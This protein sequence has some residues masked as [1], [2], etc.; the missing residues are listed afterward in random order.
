MVNTYL[1]TYQNKPL[2]LYS[3]MS[4]LFDFIL[5]IFNLP[6]NNLSLIKFTIYEYEVNRGYPIN[7]FKFTGDSGKLIFIEESKKRV[8]MNKETFSRFIK[9]KNKYSH[10]FAVKKEEP[11]IE[12]PIKQIVTNDDDIKILVENKNKV[13]N[14]LHDTISEINKMKYRNKQFSNWYNKFT[15]DVALFNKFTEELKKDEKFTIPKLFEQKFCFFTELGCDS[16][17]DYF[18]K[19]NTNSELDL[20]E[21]ENFLNENEDK[22]EDNLN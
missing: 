10:I 20:E 11:K 19:F 21:L 3:K 16:F 5:E 14:K 2:G 15:T 13:Q 1:L 9:L 17:T 18:S 12:Q 4:F 8:E 7:T 6:T 22:D